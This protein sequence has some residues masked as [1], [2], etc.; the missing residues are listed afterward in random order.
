MLK[1]LAIYHNNQVLYVFL[2]PSLYYF[3]VGSGNGRDDIDFPG[4]T[5][6][7]FVSDIFTMNF[8]KKKKHTILPVFTQIFFFFSKQILIIENPFVLF[9]FG[10]LIF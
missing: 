3:I 6:I 1:V 9:F 4:T 8:Q 10:L 5:D 7:N 2:L